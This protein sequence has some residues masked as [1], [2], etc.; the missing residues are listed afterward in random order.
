MYDAGTWLS[1]CA[2]KAANMRRV[3]CIEQ[4]RL[5]DALRQVRVCPTHVRPDS[6]PCVT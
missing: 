1:G 5:L 2:D 3:A 4:N 6:L